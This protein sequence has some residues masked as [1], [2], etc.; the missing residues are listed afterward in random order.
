M[1]RAFTAIAIL[2]ALAVPAAGQTRAHATVSMTIA[3]IA[4]VH[5]IG[6][7]RV[8]RRDAN[9]TEFATTVN[10]SANTRY[11]LAVEL[12]AAPQDARVEVRA[13]DGSFRALGPNDSV[14]VSHGGAGRAV[15]EEV[16]YRVVGGSARSE[17]PILLN[18]VMAQ[19]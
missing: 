7:P 15:P 3:P 16:R 12:P 14:V 4:F 1:R 17:E 18:F 2:A 10:V 9:M 11:D 6:A 8:A 13:A 19:S 5:S